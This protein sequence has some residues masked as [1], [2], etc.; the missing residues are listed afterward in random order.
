MNSLVASI[1]QPILSDVCPVNIISDHYHK[2]NLLTLT[3]VLN[4]TKNTWQIRL[5]TMLTLTLAP[6]C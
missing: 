2:T 1:K 6:Y 5:L 4:I 3:I